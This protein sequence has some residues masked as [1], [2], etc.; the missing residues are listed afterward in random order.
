MRRDP[1][2]LRELMLKLEAY[3]MRRGGV[4]TFSDDY[5]ELACP[6]F[7]AD[8]IDYHLKQIDHLGY[9][10]NMG[11]RPARGFGF[12][13]ITPKGHEFLDAVR[14]PETWTKTKGAAVKAGGISLDILLDV[15]KALARGELRKLG[16]TL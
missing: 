1:D 14:Q 6:G 12:A 8:E 7:T 5:E 2:L 11:T 4:V 9:V 15:A 13:I 16:L 10:D 3:P